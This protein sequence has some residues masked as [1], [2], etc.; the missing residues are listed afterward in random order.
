[1]LKNFAITATAV[2]A[3]I[4]S[5][6]AAQASC[7]SGQTSTI[8]GPLGDGNTTLGPAASPDTQ[9]KTAFPEL[10]STTINQFDN[11][12]ANY[13]FGTTLS[14]TLPSTAP[15]VK[16][17][18]LR[19]WMAE[20]HEYGTN[21]RISLGWWGMGLPA[22]AQGLGYGIT[23]LAG[24]GGVWS[25]NAVSQFMFTIAPGSVT[26]APSNT[27]PIATVMGYL[28]TYHKIDVFVEDDTMI[29]RIKLEVCSQ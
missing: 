4:V 13:H 11:H 27:I 5:A 16:Q 3:L 19:I 8:V 25:G 23:S 29:D 15:T 12:S 28:N 10:A 9:F 1:M 22:N 7:P 20:N 21:D 18:H 26:P 17:V 2:A 6:G 14:F 24:S